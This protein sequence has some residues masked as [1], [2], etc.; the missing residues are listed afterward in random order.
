M[1]AIFA[2][3]LLAVLLGELTDAAPNPATWLATK[4]ATSSGAFLVKPGGQYVSGYFGTIVA[5]ALVRARERSDL[6]LAWMGWYVAHAHGSGSGIDGVPDDID[7][8]KGAEFSR[9]RPDS[10]DAYGAIFVTLARDAYESGDP[11]LRS[12]VL[13]HRSDLVRIVDS[14]IATMQSNG[15][16]WSR[17]QHR[18][19]Y[20]IDNVQV[21]RGLL[22][23]ADL[24]R[25][26][27]DDRTTALRYEDDA[28]IVKHGI[29]TV[30]W[31]PATQSFRP[32]MNELGTSGSANLSQP[33]PDALAQLLAVYYGALDRQ[34]SVAASLVERASPA[35][36]ASENTIDEQRLI[37]YATQKRMGK[38]ISLAPFTPPALCVDAA[39]Y[40]DVLH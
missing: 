37:V 19:F 26:A 34:S 9:G 4:C 27:F 3:A 18:I 22:D 33:Y 1:I 6:A 31:D 5:D 30:L 8:F 39:W 14:S 12:F 24:F 23:A 35:L 36:L 21:Y 25:H 16:T 7:L 17:P 38:Q 15:L 10:T 20:A 32:Y 28:T 2:P 13:S 11:A 29:D 40:L